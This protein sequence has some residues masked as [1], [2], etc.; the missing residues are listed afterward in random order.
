MCQAVE[1]ALTETSENSNETQNILFNCAK[2][3]SVSFQGN[4]NKLEKILRL[5]YLQIGKMITADHSKSSKN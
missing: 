5:H 3:H 2:D 4:L 1:S